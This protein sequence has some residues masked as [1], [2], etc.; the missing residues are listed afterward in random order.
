MSFIGSRGG[1]PLHRKASDVVLCYNY[2][3]G[4]IGMKNHRSLTL[5]MWSHVNHT[6]LVWAIEEDQLYKLVSFNLV[7]IFFWWGIHK[8]TVS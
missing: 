3:V 1:G 7:S 5:N 6:S 4:R 8:A 2:M